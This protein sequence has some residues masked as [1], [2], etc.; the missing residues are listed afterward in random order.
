MLPVSPE[1]G[2]QQRE[3][4]MEAQLHSTAPSSLESPLPSGSHSGK[5]GVCSV[6][7]EKE[8]EAEKTGCGDEIY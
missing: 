5:A 3:R 8:S 4:E 2:C 1:V 7:E 6:A